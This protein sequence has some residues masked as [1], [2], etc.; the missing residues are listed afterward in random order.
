MGH[1]H[2]P[3]PQA[4][5]RRGGRK[6][7]PQ[8]GEA[9]SSALEKLHDSIVGV[10]EAQAFYR[11]SLQKGTSEVPFCTEALRT[12][13]FDEC[14]P[15]LKMDR[16]LEE[17]LWDILE[18]VEQEGLRQ[19]DRQALAGVTSR[20]LLQDD[21]EQSSAA[22]S[23]AAG[24][25]EELLGGGAPSAVVDAASTTAAAAST[26]AAPPRSDAGSATGAGGVE[27][28]EQHPP[29][30]SFSEEAEGARA[31]PAAP[32]VTSIAERYRLLLLDLDLGSVE[33][34][35]STKAANAAAIALKTL[36]RQVFSE[37]QQLKQE[38]RATLALIG[39]IERDRLFDAEKYAKMVQQF[40][41]GVR[42]RAERQRARVLS[43]AG[44]GTGIVEIVAGRDS[45]S[46]GKQRGGQEDGAPSRT[47]EGGAGRGSGGA[48]RG[49]GTKAPV[50]R[51]G[52]GPTY[53]SRAVQHR[54]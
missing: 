13:V 25:H 21:D 6:R 4:R 22:G 36:E 16:K 29:T 1:L 33:K 26:T 34:P 44:S 20:T 54:R 38:L 32:A 30:R 50:S 52:I 7:P 43:A 37:T 28:P 2:T 9:R 46:W 3:S 48:V 41:Q 53:A 17:E 49:S 8:V 45:S 18:E 39:G 51:Q 11:G 19:Q 24:D 35:D 31:A 15:L 42:D 40:K 47:V 14:L 10:R 12:V 27:D 23:S 5:I